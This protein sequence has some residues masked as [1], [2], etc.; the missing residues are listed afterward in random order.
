MIVKR[1]TPPRNAQQEREADMKEKGYV[2][3]IH[4]NFD[5][6]LIEQV[7]KDFKRAYESKEKL[8]TIDI[9][10]DGGYAHILEAI[11]ELMK[12]FRSHKGKVNTAVSKQAYSCG[13][14]LLMHGNKK[15]AY[16][17]T[18]IMIH[19]VGVHLEGKLGDLKK[20]VEELEEY[21]KEIYKGCLKNTGL[22]YNKLQ[23]ILEGKPENDWF[24][25][26]QEALK[27]RIVD[28]VIF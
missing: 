15:F 19:N 8:I 12:E 4:R 7:T 27:W 16:P 21:N 25:G 22:S 6:E 28:E 11:I 17:T 18:D 26:P 23:K 14:I 24:M 13:S 5:D 1:K 9:Q 10:S 20:Q 3:N 2:I